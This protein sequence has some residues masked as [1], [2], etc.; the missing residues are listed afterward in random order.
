MKKIVGHD[1]ETANYYTA[2]KCL[3]IDHSHANYYTDLLI[4][5]CF[6]L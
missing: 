3:N 5:V 2:S 6:S 4:F 1:D